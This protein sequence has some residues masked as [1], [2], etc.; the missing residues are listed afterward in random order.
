MR[1]IKIQQKPR[2]R[3]YCKWAEQTKNVKEIENV[4]K[5]DLNLLLENFFADVTRE[6]VNNLSRYHCSMQAALDRY[7]KE[8]GCI[9]SILKD[10]EF[11]GSRDVLEGKAKYLRKE[12]R[13]GLTPNAADSLSPPVS[14]SR[15]ISFF[16]K[17]IIDQPHQYRR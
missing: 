17:K 6:T 15:V 12:L 16:L 1:K 10:P 5:N 14:P 9:F 7:L 8:N 13:M 4:E 3:K 2:Y 11:K